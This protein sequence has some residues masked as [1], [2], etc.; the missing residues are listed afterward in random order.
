MSIAAPTVFMVDDQ[1]S[2]LKSIA[3]LLRSAGLN[4]ATFASPQKFLEHYDA[5]I[6]G[7]CWK[8]SPTPSPM[9]WASTSLRKLATVKPS[10]FAA[11]RRCSTSRS[12]QYRS[13]S[14]LACRQTDRFYISRICNAPRLSHYCF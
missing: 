2:V 12:V 6:S 10:Q 8:P 13:V 1:P 4:A 3:R 7:Y 9:D 5:S 14:R 11:I